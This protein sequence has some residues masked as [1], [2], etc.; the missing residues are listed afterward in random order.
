MDE[1]DEMDGSLSDGFKRTTGLSSS[2][3]ADVEADGTL[4][5]AS[6]R[7]STLSYPYQPS[8]SFMAVSANSLIVSLSVQISF[9]TFILG[10]DVLADDD[11]VAIVIGRTGLHYTYSTSG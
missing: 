7:R 6:S 11:A 3:V 10:G 2:M 1:K 5:A 8:I 9:F 4:L